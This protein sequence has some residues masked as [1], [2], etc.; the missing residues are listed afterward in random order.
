[1]QPAKNGAL[2]CEKVSSGPFGLCATAVKKEE[3]EEEEDE[4]WE[5]SRALST[6]R[7]TFTG[8]YG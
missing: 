1:M 6:C 8:K 5:M 3:E 2:W 4:M 7:H